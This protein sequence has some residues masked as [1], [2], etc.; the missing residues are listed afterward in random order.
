MKRCRSQR[1][2]RWPAFTSCVG[3]TEFP[4]FGEKNAYSSIEIHSNWESRMFVIFLY[5]SECLQSRVFDHN[6]TD[7]VGR[8]MLVPMGVGSCPV[9][10]R[11]FD[12]LSVF[13]AL[14]SSSTLIP[15][16]C[17]SH[18]STVTC[19]M[20]CLVQSCCYLRDM[21]IDYIGRHMVSHT[22]FFPQKFSLSIKI[23]PY[24]CASF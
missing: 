11:V 8:M 9:D 16:S 19:P 20:P 7:I 3:R 17:L 22:L 4:D 23:N 21:L 18:G 2:A 10:C 6:T 15:F 1:N 13:C 5:C 14:D 12:N 24:S